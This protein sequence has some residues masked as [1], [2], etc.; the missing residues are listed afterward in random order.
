MAVRP[1]TG[2]IVKFFKEGGTKTTSQVM[3]EVNDLTDSDIVELS[4]GISD[5]S[6]T[7]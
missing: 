6:L 1:G 7:Y 2:L 4:D 5:G 3:A